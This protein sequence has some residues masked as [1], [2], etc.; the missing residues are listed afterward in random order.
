M[1]NLPKARYLL[2]SIYRIHAGDDSGF[3][4]MVRARRARNSS[5]NLNR[6]E[7]AYEVIT[8]AG[9]GTY[10]FIAP[11]PSLKMLDDGLAKTPNYA[12]GVGDSARQTAGLTNF[13]QERLLLRVEPGMSFV[14]SE[15]AGADSYFWN[16]R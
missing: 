3:A 10:L 5:I 4:E 2:V 7:I 8:G 15:F 9:V 6:P 13:S 1:K 11:L 12:E 14:S 16:P